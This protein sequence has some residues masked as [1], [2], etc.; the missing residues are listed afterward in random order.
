MYGIYA[1]VSKFNNWSKLS[2]SI[3]CSSAW[4]STDSEINNLFLKIIFCNKYNK[5]VCTLPP[6]L[7]S[8]WFCIL[9]S[10]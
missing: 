2:T 7:E 4:C 1:T 3:F 5:N 8:E 10:L 9:N 6:S